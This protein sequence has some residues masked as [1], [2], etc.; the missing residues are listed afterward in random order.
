MNGIHK[1]SI[2]NYQNSI[3]ISKLTNPVQNKDKTKVTNVQDR[4]SLSGQKLKTT[5]SKIGITNN[6]IQQPKLNS[7]ITNNFKNN[8]DSDNLFE[9]STRLVNN[10]PSQASTLRTNLLG[11][12]KNFTNDDKIRVQKPNLKSKSPVEFSSRL[13]RASVT[14][15]LISFSMDKFKNNKSGIIMTS[16][17]NKL[18]LSP[19][20]TKN[21]KTKSTLSKIVNPMTKSYNTI[22][23]GKSPMIGF[24]ISKNS[25]ESTP[26]S[27]NSKLSS[28]SKSPLSHIDKKNNL[29]MSSNSRNKD[30][31]DK[32]YSA[33]S[34]MSND[35]KIKVKKK[36]Q[37]NGSVPSVEKL[38]EPQFNKIVESNRIFVQTT[39]S[40]EIKKNVSK[41]TNF[42]NSSLLK[43]YEELRLKNQSLK[44]NNLN[45]V[46]K[47]S[48]N[49][50]SENGFKY[51]EDINK[52]PVQ[53]ENKT[54]LHIEEENL[55]NLNANKS[56]LNSSIESGIIKVN[57]AEI[58]R[59]SEKNDDFLAQ[60]KE[61]KDNS[62]LIKDNEAILLKKRSEQKTPEPNL[63]KIKSHFNISKMGYSGP[64]VKKVNQ[65][66]LFMYTNFNDEKDCIY[67]AVCDGHGMFGHEVSSYLRDH[68]PVHLHN[69]LRAKKVDLRTCN[70]L[71]P[72]SSNSSPRPVQ[73]KEIIEDAFLSINMKL[74]NDTKIDTAF[75]GSTCV[76][77]IYTG[78]KLICANVGDSRAVVGQKKDSKWYAKNL[79]RDH[80]PSE[81]DEA[82]RIKR[83]G[84]RIE[85]YKGKFTRL[86]FR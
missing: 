14:N 42:N 10:R 21:Y 16:T 24:K 36:I 52:N 3:L 62:K 56:N 71:I 49:L 53:R 65:D 80:K 59:Q 84:G 63:F 32:S 54:S 5:A 61:N 7:T 66:N 1:R 75:S 6:Q 17:L 76:S 68:L 83:R 48:K 12:L 81:K 40:P 78:N 19:K 60:I 13:Q 45:K 37:N 28:I 39:R 46:E 25:K 23:R 4:Q 55:K 33:Y 18:K 77:V 35:S 15:D 29:D 9:N 73:I 27:S 34:P 47:I 2:S 67:T 31:F 64:G 50:K 8:N 57:R 82:A 72:K 86:F 30:S 22:L 85:A 51:N 20:K 41:I 11:Q 70:F 44:N 43:K 74:F 69:E 38:P 79:S 26:K 58:K